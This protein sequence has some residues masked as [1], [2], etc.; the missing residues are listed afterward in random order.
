MD[1]SESRQRSAGASGTSLFQPSAGD[2]YTSARDFHPTAGN[3][4]AYSPRHHNCGLKPC[5]CDVSAR[6]WG[7]FVTL[8][9]TKGLAPQRVGTTPAPGWNRSRSSLESGP[10]T[11]GSKLRSALAEAPQWAGNFPAVGWKVLPSNSR[12]LRHLA[13]AI[14]FMLL[15]SFVLLK[16]DYRHQTVLRSPLWHNERL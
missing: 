8:T 16:Q 4:A 7:P 3:C 11:A 1:M 13:V 15:Y 5:I 2:C 6:V 9:A 14:G 10:Q 12:Y